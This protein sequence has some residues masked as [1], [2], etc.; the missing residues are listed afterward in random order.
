MVMFKPCLAVRSG[1]SASNGGFRKLNWPCGR[2]CTGPTFRM[3]NGAPAIFPC[4]AL[5]CSP[6]RSKSP[7]PLCFCRPGRNPKPRA[8]G[9]DS[10][11]DHCPELGVNLQDVVL[12][13]GPRGG[14]QVLQQFQGETFVREPLLVFTEQAPKI[15]MAPL[16]LFMGRTPES[17]HA[18]LL[19]GEMLVGIIFQKIHQADD[20]FAILLGRIGDVQLLFQMIDVGDQRPVLLVEL[21]RAGLKLFGPKYHNPRRSFWA[22]AM[23]ADEKMTELLKIDKPDEY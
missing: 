22:S 5:R 15:F 17:A 12:D 8:V 1:S 21:F 7:S 10:T 23:P 20:E 11:V 2:A 4:R 16:V 19:L 13:P 6:R 9:I 18:L 3:S 14:V